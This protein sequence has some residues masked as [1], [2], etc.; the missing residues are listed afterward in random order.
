MREVISLRRRGVRKSSIS[1]G[2]DSKSIA[3]CWLPLETDKREGLPAYFRT[4]SFL[5]HQFQP[6]LDLTSH[7][8]RAGQFAE[9]GI[10]HRED[11]A[12]GIGQCERRCVR[13]VECFCSKFHV[14]AFAKANS[15]E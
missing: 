6:E 7:C 9:S 8:L 4:C 2:A 5:P 1:A 10:A 3:A 15:L 14:P 12:S 13:E 11:G